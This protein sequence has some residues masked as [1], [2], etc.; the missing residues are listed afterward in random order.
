MIT[1]HQPSYEE[2]VKLVFD[3]ELYDRMTDDN[4]PPKEEFELPT[5]GYEAIGGYLYSQIVSLFLVYGD[6]LHF[7]VLK[8]YR[9]H[10]VKL[11][12]ASF[13]MRPQTVC[14]KIA[15]LYRPV[16]NFAKNYGFKEIDI[17]PM[18]FKKNGQLY[19]IH[20]LMYEV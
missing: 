5:E 6:E 3:D 11:L 18:A 14:C 15:S 17:E 12:D 19:D 1:A 4:C 16:I 13:K 2:I 9:K 8:P 20:K 10:A 7:V